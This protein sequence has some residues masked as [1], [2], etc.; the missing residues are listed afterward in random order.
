MSTAATS[1]GSTFTTTTFTGSAPA[2]T[3]GWD[4]VYAL[5]VGIVNEALTE[6]FG[7]GGALASK[8]TFTQALDPTGTISM[9]GQFGAWQITT[10]GS[11]EQ[12]NLT[13]PIQSGTATIAGVG[14]S[15]P[16]IDLAGATIAVQ[17]S[18]G[19]HAVA[20]DASA[21]VTSGTPTTTALLK[22]VTA[23]SA[24]AAG[25]AADIKAAAGASTASAPA[26]T[27][28]VTVTGVT[29]L[30]LAS[31]D[32][33]LQM[34]AT[35]FVET[36]AKMWIA[37]NLG[38]FDY[39]FLSVDVAETAAV[40]EWSWIKPTFVGYAIT[41]LLDDDGAPLPVENSLFAIM[42]LTGGKVPG[43][44][45]DGSVIQVSPTV[46][47]NAIPT[48]AGVNAGFLIQPGLLLENIIAPNM[49]A[50]FS[51]ATSAD[52]QTSTD[53]LTIANT[54]ALTL[55][56]E[57]DPTWYPFSNPCTATIGVGDL[58]VSFTQTTV[59][60]SFSNIS[61]PYGTQNELTV[62]LSLA[63]YSTIG[64]DGKNSFTML[65]GGD[66]TSTL[67]VQPDAAKIA[68]EALEGIGVNLVV[69][70]LCC[71][72]FGAA[73][74]AVTTEVSQVTTTVGDTAGGEI[75]GG[76]GDADG[77][78]GV[79]GDASTGNRG[80]GEPQAIVNEAGEIPSASNLSTGA[81]R[82][83]G[84]IDAGAANGARAG[85]EIQLEDPDN[86]IGEN[87]ANTE[88]SSSARTEMQNPGTWTLK[89]IMPRFTFKVWAMFVGQF[90]GE[91]FSNMSNIDII[92]AYDQDPTQMPTLQ[93]F[94][95]G[96]IS[97]A[98]WTNTGNQQLV[99]AGL[100]GAFV[101]GFTVP[102]VTRTTA[103]S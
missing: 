63:S 35:T 9:T 14:L 20:P 82:V 76:E 17:V 102:P 45:P 79:G 71:L 77:G 66:T 38:I 59:Q 86:A 16:T 37:D 103:A 75:A 67:S 81:E 80:S 46:S 25:S 55:Q 89:G 57:M 42:S 12:I 11:G 87:Q 28:P 43:P 15:S 1:A 56:L 97:P 88:L 95:A 29:G 50:L 64:V 53:S 24:P 78:L 90:A 96:C 41:D 13:I 31:Q 85:G 36:L 101:M 27:Q 22:V 54:S 93:N 21:T 69:T 74:G 49:P 73:G 33:G 83:A 26:A 48:N 30:T 72:S 10:G 32:S 61:F 70:A 6:N 99:C 23:G 68:A 4:T 39:V 40:G 7:P 92:A 94:L 98:T 52:F 84:D 51:N 60:Q 2:D 65:Y 5:K 44:Q 8:L 47:V 3:A 19:F 100:N 58:S 18:L 62:E 91:V 34:L